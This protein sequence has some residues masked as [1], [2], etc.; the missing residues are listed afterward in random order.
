[1]AGR[2]LVVED[3]RQILE[4]L[5]DMLRVDGHE[6]IGLAYPEL[7][8]EVVDHERPDL[9]LL[10]IMLPKTSGIE[11]ADQLWVN[12]LGAIPI[13]AT[14]ASSV[15][16][17]LAHQT[18]FFERVVRKPFEMEKLLETVGEVLRAYDPTVVLVTE[19]ERLS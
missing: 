6:V 12:G 19:A 7:V 18:P 3:D 1:M 8:L 4:M 2:I 11:V 13:I 17:D 9:I 15:M 5:T 16:I 14:S 10:D